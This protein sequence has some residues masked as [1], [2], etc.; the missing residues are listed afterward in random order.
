MSYNELPAVVGIAA[1]L[2]AKSAPVWDEVKDNVF[3]DTTFNDANATDEAFAKAYLVV[4]DEYVIQRV[5]DIDQLQL[6][7]SGSI[8]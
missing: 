2:D 8:N 5:T 6:T 1:A 7:H 4:S 3:V